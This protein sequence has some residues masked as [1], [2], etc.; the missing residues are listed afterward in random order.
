MTT[1]K[2]VLQT[3]QAI[4]KAFNEK[5]A[6]FLEFLEIAPEAIVIFD[7][8][9]HAFTICN[10]NALELLKYKREELLGKGPEILSPEFQPDGRR[11]KDMIKEYVGR[12]INGEKL[13][14]E[15]LTINGKGETFIAEA[16][17]SP[18]LNASTPHIYTSLIDITERK[19]AQLKIENQ[20]AKLKEIAFLQSHNVRGPVA[21]IMGLIGLFDFK[22]LSNPLNSQLLQK[23]ELCVKDFDERIKEIVLKT[24]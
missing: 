9:K 18:L 23:L 16:R 3:L 6:Q 7:V 17:L 8:E 20:N 2:E 10:S 14:F 22:D 11:S 13:V 15:W 24:A 19:S 5:E 1:K 12:V 4:E 21:H